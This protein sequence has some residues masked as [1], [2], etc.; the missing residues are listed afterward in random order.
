MSLVEKDLDTLAEL[1]A[2][3]LA[4]HL[5]KEDRLL[6]RP[7]LATRLGVSERGLTGLVSRGELPAGFLI[8]GLRR[9]HWAQVVRFLESRSGRRPRRGR[10]RRM[11]ADRR[12]GAEEE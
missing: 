10:G 7:E 8:G 1:I 5:G 6:S 2:G 4:K 3:K 11:S 9:W 12:P